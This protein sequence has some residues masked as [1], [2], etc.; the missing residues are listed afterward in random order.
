MIELS[1]V[2]PVFDEAEVLTALYERLKPVLDRLECVYELLFVDDG[3]RDASWQQIRRLAETDG[4]VRGISLSRN[5]GHQVAL[6]AGLDH[7]K[8]EAV[9][10]MDADLQ[11][12]PELIPQLIARYREGYD[13]VVTVRRDASRTGLAKR[14]SSRLFYR[15]INSLSEIRI[16]PSGADFR[17]MS[18]RAVEAFRQF[19]ERARFTRGLIAWMGFSRATVEYTAQQRR[20]GE[21]KYT[22][23][24]MT[25]LALDAVTA[26]SSRPLRLSLYLGIGLFCGACAYTAYAV[27]TFFAGRAAPGWTSLLLSV[28]L[29]G[30][31]Q[32]ISVGVLGE[33]I[34]RVF[35]EVKR[36]PLYFVAQETP[37]RPQ[38]FTPVAARSSGVDA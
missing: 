8:G 16:E 23:R 21:S 15:L 25:S 37:G 19:G 12:P 4:C 32:L 27:A 5:F 29:L 10:T 26:F 35:D 3:S 31:I 11:H 7:A 30:G 17:L 34:G 36:R 38:A 33:Y 20:A 6:T 18:R 13:V 24:R 28:L 22:V 14:W 1:V 9:I 2:I